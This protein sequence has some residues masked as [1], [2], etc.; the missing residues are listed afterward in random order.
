MARI[1][2]GRSQNLVSELLTTAMMS[3][4][5]WHPHPR[6]NDR[7][8]AGVQH[9]SHHPRGPSPEISPRILKLWD[10]SQIPSKRWDQRRCRN[11]PTISPRGLVKSYVVRPSVVGWADMLESILRKSAGSSKMPLRGENIPK[12]SFNLFSFF[13]Y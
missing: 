7:G 13:I 10:H 3:Q 1:H 2:V 12:S 8:V 9:R 4:T 5:H 6:H 11:R